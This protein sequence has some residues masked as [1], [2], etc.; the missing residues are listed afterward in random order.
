MKTGDDGSL[1]L[2]GSREGRGKW[3]DSGNILKMESIGFL[4]GMEW[5]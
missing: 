4:D 1:D 2:D 3:Q 5:T